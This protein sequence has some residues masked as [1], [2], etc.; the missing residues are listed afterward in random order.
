[1]IKMAR[2]TKSFIKRT[3]GMVGNKPRIYNIDRDTY[4]LGYAQ[5]NQ[6]A[7]TS[8]SRIKVNKGFLFC[9]ASEVTEGELIQD[10][11]DNK[12]YFLMSAKME[13]L[14]GEA[15]Y[16]DCALYYC[17]ATATIER[18]TDG[19]RD[20][21]GT[22]LDPTPQVIISDIP[23][24]TNPQTYDTLEQQDRVIAN[25]KIRIFVQAKAGVKE[26]DRVVA[27][28]GDTYKITRIDKVSWPGIWTCYVDVDVR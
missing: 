27:S 18:W 6:M 25:D 12:K 24:V 21:F 5:V 28:S 10:R 22:V 26:F 14:N 2:M 7:T 19:A 3:M 20:T 15:V 16:I 8:F 17:D 13:M 4:L 23:I 9:E 1:M 11:A